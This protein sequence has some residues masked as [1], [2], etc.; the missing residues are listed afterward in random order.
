MTSLFDA[1]GQPVTL[2]GKLAEGGEGSVFDVVGRPDLVAKL[3]L[4]QPE[5]LR[6][7][8]LQVMSQ[9]A[10]SDLLRIA[11]WPIS[12]LHRQMRSD[13]VGF[14]MPR[15]GGR[16]AHVLYGPKQRQTEF[17]AA[18]WRFLLAAARNIAASVATV[19]A[20]GHVIG[21]INQKG[22]L[23]GRDATVRLIDCDSFQIS[24]NGRVFP[25]MVGVPEFTAPELHGQRLDSTLRTIHHDG[26][27]LA[28][29]V[30]QVLFMGR[31]PFAGR[32]VGKGDM[33]PERAIREFRFAYSQSAAA[34]EMLPPPHALNLAALPYDIA[35]LFE[36]AFSPQGS[37]N[38]RPLASEWVSKLEHFSRDLKTCG[39]D[40]AHKFHSHVAACPWCAIERGGGPAFFLSVGVSIDVRSDFDLASLLR[41]ISAIALGVRPDAPPLVTPV[42]AIPRPVPEEVVSRKRLAKLLLVMALLVLLS[43]LATTI[44][45]LL[46]FGAAL[47]GIGVLLRSSPA[48]L[49]ER[50]SRKAAL[51]SAVRAW[52]HLAAA[53]RTES[54]TMLDTQ[55]R[56]RSAV[57]QLAAV[58]K[59]LPN[60]L[61]AEQTALHQQREVLQRKAYL[62]RHLVYDAKLDGIGA[63]LKQILMSYGIE[64]ANDVTP[65]LQV[66]GI[67]PARLGTLL[68]WRHSVESR[69]RFDANKSV[70]PADVAAVKHRFALQKKE[71]ERQLLQSRVEMQDLARRA[72]AFQES[73]RLRLQE[74]ADR[75]AQARADNAVLR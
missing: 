18:D 19:H 64:T 26:F 61:Q 58:Y 25:C 68:N 52:D 7:E 71:L 70:N 36:R 5:R 39:I 67:G 38:G 51:D 72:K 40:R 2:G 62:E 42:A 8:K 24:M 11:A 59:E 22:F 14:L 13:P 1:T 55:Q 56:I 20:A 16:E 3:Y 28:V 15:V 29:L 63:G 4:K 35:T 33:P 47:G 69:F 31:H 27:G 57:N 50:A 10:N 74:A 37:R 6:I 53:W 34:K 65:F 48:L 66:S 49:N 60:K 30:F 73:A 43:G 32:F 54:Q 21:D 12:V 44:P 9:L 41:E 17:P 23:I 45:A 75:L 46:I